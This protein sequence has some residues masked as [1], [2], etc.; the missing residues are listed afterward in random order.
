MQEGGP[1]SK[2][3]VPPMTSFSPHMGYACWDEVE[4]AGHLR[5]TKS[6]SG[7]I[8]PMSYNVDYVTS[9]ADASSLM[10]LLW[11]DIG[12]NGFKAAMCSCNVISVIRCA[13]ESHALVDDLRR[14]LSQSRRKTEGNAWSCL[15]IHCRENYRYRDTSLPTSIPRR[16]TSPLQHAGQGQG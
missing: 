12:F 10:S 9:Y 5:L 11:L 4:C 15:F 3:W 1:P 16:L 14:S 13:A 7:T 8:P 6:L 2:P